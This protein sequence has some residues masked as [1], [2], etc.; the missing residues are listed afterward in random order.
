M[1]FRSSRSLAIL[2]VSFVSL[3]LMGTQCPLGLKISAYLDLHASGVDRYVGEFH[4]ASSEEMGDWT[5]HTFD[6]DGG[7]GPE[8]IDGSPFTVFTRERD[9]H[10]VVIFLNGGGACWQNFYNCTI[11]ASSDPPGPGGIFADSFTSGSTTIA[12]PL[13]DWSMMFVSYCDGSVFGGDN[14]V[15]DPSF[16]VPSAGGVRRH[17]GVRNVTAA[18]D[19]ARDTWPLAAKVLLSGSSAGGYGVAGVSPFI[20]RFNWGNLTK[21]YVFNDSGPAV[22]NLAQPSVIQTRIDD[23]AYTQFNPSSCTDCTPDKQPA[24]LVEWMLE[25]DGQVRSALYSTDADATI[26]FFLSDPFPAPFMTQAQYRSLLLTTHDPINAEFPTRHKRFI[27]SGS[28]QHTALGSSLFYTATINGVPLY[29]W[30][31]DFVDQQS[32]WVDLVQDLI[33]SPF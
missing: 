20:V 1:T 28:T 23:W 29:Q 18:I 32:G 17:R 16:P 10:K 8:C 22:T 27:R 25:N 6:A 19:L 13:A 5:K 24:E 7:E 31:G 9:P 3:S 14:D 11:T 26:R 2:A 33:P 12:N 15:T 21:L 30:T 4:P